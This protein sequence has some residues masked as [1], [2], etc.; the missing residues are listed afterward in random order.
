VAA[1][2]SR[3]GSRSHHRHLLL[4]QRPLDLE[5]G[6]VRVRHG[7]RIRPGP[8]NHAVGD[9]VIDSVIR[10]RVRIVREAVETCRNSRCF[11]LGQR[12]CRRQVEPEVGEQALVPLPPVLVTVPA[13]FVPQLLNGPEQFALHRVALAAP[14]HL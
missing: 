7:I 11:I 1:R 14:R 12:S 2:S 9:P 10:L 8:K 4:V 6:V 5:F 3:A 13:S